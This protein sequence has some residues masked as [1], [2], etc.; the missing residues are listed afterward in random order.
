MAGGKL[1]FKSKK[2]KK[3]IQSGANDRPIVNE[4]G[5]QQVP[6]NQESVELSNSLQPST[7]VSEPSNK[8]ATNPNTSTEPSIE[9]SSTQIPCDG[10]AETDDRTRRNGRG[11]SR[12]T[13][14]PSDPSM[15][16]RLTILDGSSFHQDGVVANIGSKLREHYNQA[17]S[18]WSQFEKPTKDLLWDRF[19]DDENSVYKI[20]NIKCDERLRDGLGK[21]RD[22]ARKKAGCH[23]WNKMKPFHPKWI[24]PAV[25][26]KLIDDVWSKKEWVDQSEQASVNRKSSKDG[27]ISKHAG[28]SRPFSKHKED[29]DK[30]KSLVEEKYGQEAAENAQFDANIWKSAGGVRKRGQLYGFGCLQNSKRLHGST[31]SM[32]TEAPPNASSQQTLFSNEAIQELFNKFLEEKLPQHLKALGFKPIDPPTVAAN[33]DGASENIEAGTSTSPND[34]IQHRAFESNQAN[35]LDDNEG[36]RDDEGDLGRHW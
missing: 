13:V 26:V 1:Q 11:P 4:T 3:Q 27:C 14:T 35:V 10:V 28:G 22:Q 25:W 29:L 16:T 24:P 20:W 30:Y 12:G 9:P 36:S 17:W 23:D 15:K 2:K 33:Q 19:K 5:V 31:S 34:P 8:A 6:T 21:A 18:T 7:S 32:N